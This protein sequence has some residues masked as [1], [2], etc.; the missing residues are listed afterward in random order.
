MIDCR[1]YRFPANSRAQELTI[2]EQVEYLCGEAVEVAEAGL[3]GGAAHVIEEL[4]DVIHTAEGALRKFG[5]QRVRDGYYLVMAKNMERG[6]YCIED[7][8]RS[9][10]GLA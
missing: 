8:V 1:V 2:A 10:W 4:W 5:E 7:L 9:D 3:D 6:D